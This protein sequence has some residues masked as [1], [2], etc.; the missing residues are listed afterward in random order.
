VGKPKPSLNSNDKEG[1]LRAFTDEW[2]D[3][4]VE[5]HVVLEFTVE[6]SSRKGVLRFTVTAL[7]PDDGRTTLAQAYYQCEY[8]TAAVQSVEACMFA[9]MVKLERILRDRKAHPMGKA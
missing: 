4:Q 6:P 8:P 2:L 1:F 5:Y 3:L 9:C 7:D